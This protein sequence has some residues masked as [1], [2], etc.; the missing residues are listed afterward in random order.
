MKSNKVFFLLF[1]GMIF[2]L[3]FFSLLVTFSSIKGLDV[4]DKV[5]IAIVGLV[6]MKY[7]LFPSDF[8]IFAIIYGVL[9]LGF[10]LLKFIAI[11]IPKIHFYNHNIITMNIAKVYLG[12]TFLNT[13]LPFLFYWVLLKSINS[14][15]QK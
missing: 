15:K 1:I 7:T 9:W 14:I 4:F 6:I 12:I 3:W 13:P 2:I 10:F 8:K 11:V 5:I